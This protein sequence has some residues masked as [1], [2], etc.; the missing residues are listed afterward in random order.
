MKKTKP[1]E[2]TLKFDG[3]DKGVIIGG[4]A[5]IK[6]DRKE[7]VYFEKMKGDRWKMFFTT[8]AM[9][10]DEFQKFKGFTLEEKR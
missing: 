7:F 6:T 2:W 3:L 1:K 9:T 8:S 5:E 10:D 4:I